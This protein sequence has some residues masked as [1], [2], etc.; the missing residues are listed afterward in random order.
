MKTT[1]KN[2]KADFWEERWQE[3]GKQGWDIGYPSTPIK[4]YID[5]LEDKNIKILIPG[6][7]NGYEA[8]YLYEKG[9][10]NVFVIDI[11]ATAL[12]NFKQRF[13]DFP[14]ENCFCGNF[15]QHRGQYDL[16]IEQT[17]F[18]AIVPELRTDYVKQCYKCLK[19]KGKIVGLLFDDE[20]YTDHPPYGGTKKI[21]SRF[22]APYFDIEIMETAYNS[23]EPRSGRELFVKMVKKQE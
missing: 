17:F 13:P 2:I 9:F 22:F 19:S 20:L 7:G 11:S 12:K 23:I 6:S 18:C 8:Q 4:S 5:Q 16:I 1:K 14:E 3:D 21:Y 15:F 10:Q